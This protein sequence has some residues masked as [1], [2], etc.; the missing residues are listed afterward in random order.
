MGRF[1]SQNNQTDLT[2]YYFVL[3]FDRT[4][5][6]TTALYVLFQEIIESVVDNDAMHQLDRVRHEV[7]DKGGSFDSI[8][9]V[10]EILSA[11]GKS[12]KWQTIEDEFIRRA[13]PD[14]Y[15]EPGARR[16]IDYLDT[17]RC[18]Y[19]IVTFGGEQWQ[20]LKIRA[21]GLGDVPA[22]VT[23]TQEKGRLLSSW[24][25]SDGLFLIPEEL[26]GGVVVEVSTIVLID[27][28][29]LNFENFPDGAIGFYVQNATTR[30]REYVLAPSQQIYQVERL[31][32]AVALLD[33][34]IDKT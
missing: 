30:N 7:E 27:D 26:T 3:D 5:G 34:V 10:K 21:V 33:H 14:V 15:L 29:P 24:R 17:H 25:Q 31:D 32:E 2:A 22:I 13:N 11:A 12:D 6:N 1:M 19:G 18:H 16:L 9:Y 4:L 20:R 8:Y 23:D 28:N